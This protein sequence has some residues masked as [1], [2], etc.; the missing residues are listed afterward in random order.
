MMTRKNEIAMKK[1]MI[2]ERKLI[3]IMWCLFE[4]AYVC[5]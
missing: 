1:L 5:G 4:L 2:N 3:I